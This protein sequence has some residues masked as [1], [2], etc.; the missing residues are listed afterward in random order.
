LK[1]ASSQRSWLGSRSPIS[2]KIPEPLEILKVDTIPLLVAFVGL[3]GSVAGTL[4]GS[5]LTAQH[6]TGKDITNRR[7]AAYKK[8]LKVRRSYWN[9]GPQ[10]RPKKARKN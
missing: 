2:M 5:Y 1:L 8:F 9:P 4:I 10:I 7:V 6:Q 3:G